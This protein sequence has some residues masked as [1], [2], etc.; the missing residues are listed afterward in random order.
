MSTSPQAQ[1]PT[2]ANRVPGPGRTPR[3]QRQ[4][5]RNSDLVNWFHRPNPQPGETFPGRN[6]RSEDLAIA[7]PGGVNMNPRG[8]GGYLGPPLQEGGLRPG[9]FPKPLNRQLGGP[10]TM[11]QNPFRSGQ[12]QAGGGK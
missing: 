2:G 11:I 8:G 10:G 1:S 9:G 4:Y 12:F 3:Q 7:P 5:D 6:D